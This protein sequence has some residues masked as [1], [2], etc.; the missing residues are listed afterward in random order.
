MSSLVKVLKSLNMISVH[1]LLPL[2]CFQDPSLVL[3][4]FFKNLTDLAVTLVSHSDDVRLLRVNLR[5]LKDTSMFFA[6]L[7][8]V[9]FSHA[10]QGF[11]LPM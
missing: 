1:T 6:F 4:V 2:H 3:F 5:D 9:F 10:K 11:T 8:T 7:H